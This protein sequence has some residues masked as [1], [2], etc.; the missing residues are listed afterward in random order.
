MTAATSEWIGFMLTITR[1]GSA[2]IAAVVRAIAQ[3]IALSTSE[4]LVIQPLPWAD[5]TSG[6]H[7][8][9]GYDII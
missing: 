7:I 3:A 9:D 4:R 8:G 1:G 5:E 2:A 6:G